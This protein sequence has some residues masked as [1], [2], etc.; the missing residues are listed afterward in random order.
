[1]PFKTASELT[2]FSKLEIADLF[3]KIKLRFRKLGLE[4]MLA[5][6]S[7]DYARLLMCVARRFGN[8]PQR[9]LFKRRVRAIFYENQLF[10]RDFDLI[11][12]VKS[13]VGLRQK[14]ENLKTV[15][16]SDTD[17]LLGQAK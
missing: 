9:N 16:I 10:K 15:M 11:I 12:V 14:F 17:E 8:A 13:K 5:P 4:I 6:R 1:M 2:K 3:G 7:L